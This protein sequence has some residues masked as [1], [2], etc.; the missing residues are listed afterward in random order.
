MVGIWRPESYF[1][2]DWLKFILIVILRIYQMTHENFLN[3]LRMKSND[4][5]YWD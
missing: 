1:V 4:T 5:L 3:V 2:A